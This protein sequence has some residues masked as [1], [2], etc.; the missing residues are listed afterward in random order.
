[1]ITHAELLGE[2]TF[3]PAA[4][5][6]AT[7]SASSTLS[8]AADRDFRRNGE[9]KLTEVAKTIQVYECRLC[10]LSVVLDATDMRIRNVYNRAHLPN[11]LRP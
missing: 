7:A 6:P 1:M 10:G 2:L 8:R 4:G 9:G 11:A 5:R 3:L